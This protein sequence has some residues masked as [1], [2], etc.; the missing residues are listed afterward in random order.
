MTASYSVKIIWCYRWFCNPLLILRMR[1]ALFAVAEGWLMLDMFILVL[2]FVTASSWVE[3]IGDLRHMQ[4]YFSHIC[5]GID[6]Q[7][8]WVWV[9]WRFTSHATIFQSYT[10]RHRCAGG[11]K[12]LYLRSGSKRHRRF[13][14]FFNVSVLHCQGTTL[15]Y[16]VIPT[17]R[18]I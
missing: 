9:Y 6:V 17:Y 8:E 16:T 2:L 4:R 10:W 3:F 1:I 5:Y 14:G 18:L 7:A 12:K 11:L 13:V 15:F